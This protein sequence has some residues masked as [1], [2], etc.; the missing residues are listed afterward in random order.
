M[1]TE[2]TQK[3]EEESKV[4]RKFT[5][6]LDKLIAIVNGKENLK[7]NRK[8]PKNQV[9]KLVTDLFAE[10][11][12]ATY[13]SIKVSLKELLKQYTDMLKLVRQK[14][15]ELKKA[16]NEKKEEFVKA[17]TAIFDRIENIGD[18]EKSYYDSLSDLAN[19]GN[20]QPV[21]AN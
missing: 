12:E 15:Q 19:T 17:A 21:I 1:S 3:Q 18:L 8:L 20:N 13:N 14:E 9:S 16:E 4:E 6:A 2:N 11:T 10:E 7:L 5:A